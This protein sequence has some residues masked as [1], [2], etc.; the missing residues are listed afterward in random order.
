M[1]ET[2]SRGKLHVSAQAQ[3]ATAE[4]G[5]HWDENGLESREISLPIKAATGAYIVRVYTDLGIVNKQVII[6]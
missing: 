5:F 3:P 4:S 6:E 1:R 2:F